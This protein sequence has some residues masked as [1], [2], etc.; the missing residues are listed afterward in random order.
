MWVYQATHKS[1][2]SYI[3]PSKYPTIHQ[4]ALDACDANDGLTDGVIEDPE[5]CLFDPGTLLCK[6]GD[7][8]DCLT[9]PQVKPY[10]RFIKPPSTRAHR[11]ED[12]RIDAAGRRARLGSDG[13]PRSVS[14]RARVSIV[15]W[16]STRTGTTRHIR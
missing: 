11:R 16:C 2:A 4:G 15:S 6:N 8:P 10:A 12:L 5:R 14:V 1:E 3:P 13:R 9:A 7:A